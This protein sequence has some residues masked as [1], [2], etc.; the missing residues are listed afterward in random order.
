MAFHLKPED[1][2]GTSALEFALVAPV[3][4][5]ILFGIIEYGWYVTHWIVLNNAVSAGVR[6]GIKANE[7]EDEDPETLAL[8]A[9]KE[10][11]WIVQLNDRDIDIEIIPYEKDSPRRLKV[12]VASLKYKPVTGYLSV[13]SNA[14]IPQHL[15]AK[16]VMAFP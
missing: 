3:L 15:A 4:L 7:W 13:V 14:I 11:C 1:E 2:Q 6:A 5:L 10:A 9:V 16:A 8:S 12:T